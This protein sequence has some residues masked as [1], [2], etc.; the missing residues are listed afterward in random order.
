MGIIIG[1]ISGMLWGLND[2]LTNVYS[3][4]VIISTTTSSVLVFALLL[5]FIQ[6]TFSCTSIFGYHQAKNSFKRNF[7]TTT[8][9]TFFP[10]LLAAICS[11]PLG[12]VAGIVSIAYAGPIYAG[13]VTSCYPIV[14]LL[15]SITLLQE[16]PTKLKIAGIILS[17]IAVV[18]IST[19]GVRSG[20]EN[21]VIGLVFASCAMIGWGMESVLF[22]IVQKQAKH[23]VSW[24]LAIRQACS[25]LSY[26]VILG[27]IGLINYQAILNVLIDFFLPLL[28]LGCT[29]TA[30]AS[31]FTYYHTIRLIGPSMGTTF[32]ASFVF[33]AGL[34]SVLFHIS[35][36]Q[37]SF[38]L[39]S[40]V[41]VMGI[42][43]AS[44]ANKKA[45][46]DI[47]V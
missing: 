3:Q 1:I 31:Y 2:V 8:K 28:M 12:M 7:S 21:I 5:S 4:E 19:A 10:L 30:T 27:V 17:V 6:D 14:A 11:G 43:L 34:F 36:V 15:L 26:L 23:T 46:G 38:V 29:L 39:W 33:W 16:R 41:L 22:S 13:A 44:T 40:I 25:A 45:H 9:K 47:I 35:Q 37:L 20:A 24:L 32:N 42:Y 18:F